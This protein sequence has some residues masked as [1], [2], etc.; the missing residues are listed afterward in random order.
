MA[1]RLLRTRAMGARHVICALALASTS[2]A[3]DED[4][5]R[6]IAATACAGGSRPGMGALLANGGAT[7]RVWAPLAQAVWVTGDFNGWGWTALCG[8]G[9]GNFSG[10]VAVATAGQRY[11][12]IVRNAWGADSWKADPRARR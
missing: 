2:C 6:I 5:P 12:Y 10:D 8:E 4:E 1:P 3:L 9:N 7:F 11:K